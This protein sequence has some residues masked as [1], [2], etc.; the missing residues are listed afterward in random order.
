MKLIED[1]VFGTELDSALRAGL[2]QRQGV[3]YILGMSPLSDIIEEIQKGLLDDQGDVQ[4]TSADNDDK[5]DD[6]E[7][8]TDPVGD[9]D[10][11]A[12]VSRELAAATSKCKQD[13]GGDADKMQQFV[14]KCWRKIATYVLLFQESADPNKVKEAL[15]DT[16]VNRLRQE[17]MTEKVAERRFVLINYDLKTAGEA[18]SH[19]STRLPPLRTNGEHLKSL[20]RGCIAATGGDLG[21]RDLFLLFDGGRPGVL[22]GVWICTCYSVLVVVGCRG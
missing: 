7:E 22:F 6:A 12:E 16:E 17:G 14:D 11:P 1:L 5:S 3:E 19:A 4:K 18:T 13:G 15:A 20:L 21:P 10:L 2:K 9:A 8:P